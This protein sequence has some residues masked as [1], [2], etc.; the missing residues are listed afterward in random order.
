MENAE[1]KICPFCGE[2]IKEKAVKCRY[3]QSNLDE[4]S[5]VSVADTDKKTHEGNLASDMLQTIPWVE[6]TY[7]G[8]VI[9][10]KPHGSGTLKTI[11]GY[12]Y[13]GKWINGKKHGEGIMT[14]P[15]GAK[16]I[17]EWE[18]D[19]PIEGGKMIYPGAN[20]EWRSHSTVGRS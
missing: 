6:G 19:Q 3:C 10:K 2:E 4:E 1:T 7:T 16:F 13:E 12:V 11:D 9:D 18:D 17:G 20:C 8:Q 15:T 5:S 14:Y